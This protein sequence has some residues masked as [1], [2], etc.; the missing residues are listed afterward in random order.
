MVVIV[1]ESITL[2]YFGI[3]LIT[4]AWLGI[5]SFNIIGPNPVA[6]VP[7]LFAVPS[8]VTEIIFVH[9]IVVPFAGNPVDGIGVNLLLF[10]L[11]KYCPGVAR[12]FINAPGSIY[13]KS[14]DV[15]CPT[16]NV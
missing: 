4:V 13:V 16:F 6:S 9:N 1:L 12:N 10:D 15:N 5:I 2:L 8:P 11:S 14:V 7:V 3:I